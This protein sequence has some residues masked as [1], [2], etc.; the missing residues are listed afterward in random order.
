MCLAHLSTYRD[1]ER[2]AST[3]SAKLSRA[4][5]DRGEKKVYV[6]LSY[7]HSIALCGFGEAAD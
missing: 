3:Y 6:V 1:K 2:R 7:P 4:V 5:L